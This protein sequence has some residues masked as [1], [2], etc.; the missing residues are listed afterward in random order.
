MARPLALVETEND[1]GDHDQQ[2][3]QADDLTVYVESIMDYTHR[4]LPDSTEISP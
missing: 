4:I 1:E 3:D 2:R